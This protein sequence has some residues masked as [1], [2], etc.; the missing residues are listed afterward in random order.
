MIL[1]LV[2]HTTLFGNVLLAVPVGALAGTVVLLALG[3]PERRPSGSAVRIALVRN[4]LPVADIELVNEPSPGSSSWLAAL[5]D[6]GRAT[7]SWQ[8]RPGGPLKCSSV[9]TASLGSRTSLATTRSSRFA[10]SWSTERCCHTRHETLERG[11]RPSRPSHQS[12]STPCWPLSITSSRHPSAEHRRRRQAAVADLFR[13]LAALRHRRI[14]HGRLKDA[15]IRVATDGQVWLIGLELATLA[16]DDTELDLDIAQ[17]LVTAAARHRRAKRGAAR[18]RRAR[19]TPSGA[20]CALIQPAVFAGVTRTQLRTRHGLLA[21]VSTQVQQQTGVD[22]VHLAQL[23]R[24]DRK[25]LLPIIVLAGATYSLAL[26]S[27]PTYREWREQLRNANWAWTPLIVATTVVTYVGKLPGLPGRCRRMLAGLAHDQPG[28]DVVHRHGCASPGSVHGAQRAVRPETG[29]RSRCRRVRRRPR[30]R[31]RSGRARV[32]P[33]GVRRAGRP[34]NVSRLQ[35]AE[36]GV[37][38]ARRR[39]VVSSPSPCSP[40]PPPGTCS[41]STG[42]SAV[43]RSF[44]GISK[45]LRRPGSSPCCSAARPSSPSGTSW[46]C[47]SPRRVGR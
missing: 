24:L 5:E 19:P 12:V 46:R 20:A 47:S 28:G 37:A 43:R 33:G 14:A 31:R 32:A 8:A 39:S 2:V 10:M 16:A 11:R 7:S 30:H 36:P 23:E 35:P 42:A 29:R 18:N 3:R 26:T 40:S 1:R 4:G 9:R 15:T 6:G 38:A 27:S 41:P 17:A 22:E 25:T 34:A 44:D 21:D 45:V 13:Q